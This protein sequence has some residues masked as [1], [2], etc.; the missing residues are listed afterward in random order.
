[1]S[2]LHQLN[3]LPEQRTIN[4]IASY[5]NDFERDNFDYHQLLEKLH[6]TMSRSH[7]MDQQD[8]AAWMNHRGNDYLANPKL[9]AHAPLTYLCA[10]LS[11][12]FKNNQLD[13]IERNIEPNIFEAILKRLNDFK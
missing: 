3:I 2:N 1:M 9:F 6:S 11:E 13:D 8:N 5:S 10:F 12:I 4:L 7:F